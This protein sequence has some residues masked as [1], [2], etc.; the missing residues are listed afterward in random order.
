M[1]ATALAADLPPR[2]LVA[3]APAIATGWS[4]FYVGGNFGYGWGDGNMGTA[5]AS[6][7]AAIPAVVTGFFLPNAIGPL[8]AKP[9]GVIGGAQLGYLWQSGSLVT[10]WEADFQGSGIA[11]SARTS[12][13]RVNTLDG[14]DGRV[15]STDQR[16]TW[17]GTVRGRLGVTVAPDLLLY[18]TG[19][20]AYGAVSNSA[21]TRIFDND[22]PVSFPVD[23]SGGASRIRAGWTAGAGAE[24]MFARQW[25]AR[26]EYLHVDLGNVSAVANVSAPA[27]TILVDTSIKYTWKSQQDIVR[28]GVNYHF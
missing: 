3:K 16:L 4:G 27:A 10:G 9:A 15:A 18:G 20:L 12:T 13:L 25:S 21:T 2:G 22:G 17:F 14:I 5:G 1:P 7:P 23:Y 26:V 24:W 19:G 8:Q 11:G 28:A 6:G